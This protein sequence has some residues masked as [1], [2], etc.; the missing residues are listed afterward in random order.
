ME[1]RRLA[2]VIRLYDPRMR[3]QEKAEE[4]RRDQ[5]RIRDGDLAHVVAKNNLLAVT[6]EHLREVDADCPSPDVYAI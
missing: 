5:E 2:L 6:R 1:T 4:R 3:A